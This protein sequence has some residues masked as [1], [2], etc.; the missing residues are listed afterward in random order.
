MLYYPYG[1]DSDIQ[2][3]SPKKTAKYAPSVRLQP[4]IKRKASPLNKS[5]PASTSKNVSTNNALP[6]KKNLPPIPLPM[7][8]TPLPM[9]KA[10]ASDPQ[11]AEE[12]GELSDL[13]GE[14]EKHVGIS[15]KDE[16]T[17]AAELDNLWDRYLGLN[18]KDHKGQ[19][20][21]EDKLL[22]Q[23]QQYMDF[24]S[25]SAQ[26][27]PLPLSSTTATSD[28]APSQIVPE[29]LKWDEIYKNWLPTRTEMEALEPLVYIKRI[30]YEGAGFRR[31][32][33]AQ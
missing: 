2:I 29:K 22:K 23:S 30:R 1:S 16:K 11:T 28:A 10:K 4:A 31:P 14:D 21:H 5:V 26:N 3:F 9:N 25:K 12:T 17:V 24:L 6:S 15:G 7:N 13:G 20:Y 18:P 19:K 27:S 32:Y 33:Y 8:K